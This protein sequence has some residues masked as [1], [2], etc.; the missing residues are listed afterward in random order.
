MKENEL[1]EWLELLKEIAKKAEKNKN[2]VDSDGRGHHGK[3][4]RNST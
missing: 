1:P 2:P 3:E 4:E